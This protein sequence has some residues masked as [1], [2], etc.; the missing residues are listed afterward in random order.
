MRT[1]AVRF[2]EHV[3]SVDKLMDFDR[4][5]LKVAIDVLRPLPE[6]LR[7]Q[8]IDNPEL[9][10]ER[11]LDI[12]LGIRDHD[13]LRLRYNLVFNQA[14]VL[15]VSYFASSVHDLFRGAINEALQSH[16]AGA[17]LFREELCLSLGFLKEHDFNLEDLAADL[18]IQSKE[19][20]FQDMQSIA[21]A[22]KSYLDITIEKDET[23]N[24]II[25]GQAFRHVIVHI[26][27]RADS[28][29]LRQLAAAKPRTVKPDIVV[30]AAIQF[31]PH[32]VKRVAEAMQR[33][34]NNVSSL[35]RDKLGVVV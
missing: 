24:D 11:A 27:G 35:V 29:L 10:G 8:G 5:V 23:V 7:R 28:K 22:F 12:L 34:M 21:R 19:L 6:R 1:V 3:R 26:G 20:S 30:G 15:L 18:L 9:T 13:S 17:S 16:P 4:D 25:A 2:A 14:L 31:D 33:Y 32:E